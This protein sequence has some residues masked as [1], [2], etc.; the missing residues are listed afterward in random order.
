MWKRYRELNSGTLES[1]TTLETAW[2]VSPAAEISP[3]FFT[4]DLPNFTV[5]FFFSSLSLICVLSFSKS[6]TQNKDPNFSVFCSLLHVFLFFLLIETQVPKT[7]LFRKNSFTCFFRDAHHLFDIKLQRTSIFHNKKNSH[8][9]H[10]IG[11][12]RSWGFLFKF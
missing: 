5:S 1:P 9:F 2:P 11:Y 7:F 4:G 12:S 6:N 8:L 3:Y 10:Y